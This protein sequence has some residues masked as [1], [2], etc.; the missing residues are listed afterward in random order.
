MITPTKKDI[1]QEYN[2][3]DAS[4]KA[5]LERIY[6]KVA[7]ANDEYTTLKTLADCC[8]KQEV[9]T[10]HVKITLH[11]S[12]SKYEDFL[13]A[14]LESAIIRDAI[15]NSEVVKLGQRRYYPYFNQEA[16]VGF[17]FSDPVFGYVTSL[18]G[19]RLEFSE[20]KHSDYFGSNFIDIHKRRLAY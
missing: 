11:P 6:G 12:L 2:K 7:F 16:G 17:R 9:D 5:M 3:A 4:G 8:K 15:T 18:L 13:Q 14:T 19:S 1:L 10:E 20:Q